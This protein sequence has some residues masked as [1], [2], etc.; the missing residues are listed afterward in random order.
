[1][2]HMYLQI[3]VQGTL[4]LHAQHFKL[5]ASLVQAGT[6]VESS[7]GAKVT[8]LLQMPTANSPKTALCETAACCN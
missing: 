6:P 3:N 2:L 4:A 1:M 7:L 5:P 8:G